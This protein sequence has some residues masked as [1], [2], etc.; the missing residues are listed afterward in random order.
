MNKFSIKD[1]ET[2]TG[3]KSHTIR[4][5]EQRYNFLDTK[6]TDTNIRFYSDDDLRLLLNVATLNDHGYKISEI[7]KMST[8]EMSIK[9][10]EIA[11]NESSYSIYIKSLTS[12][13]L[14]FNE[15]LFKKELSNCIKKIGLEQAVLQ[16]IYPFLQNIGVLWQT[17]MM[18]PAQEHFASS[19]IKQRL[20][21][22]I[23]SL[24][25]Q[26]LESPKKFLLFLPDGEFHEIAL[27]FAYYIIKC[28]GH[29][30]LYLGQ[31]LTINYVKDV[32][33]SYEPDYIFSVLTNSMQE[34]EAEKMLN[35][36][37]SNFQNNQ[38]ILAGGRIQE[39]HSIKPK[40]IV[41]LSEVP[42]LLSFLNELNFEIA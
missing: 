27:L 21:V 40:N 11:H 17:G 33:T 20:I 36:F 29:E 37:E 6:R 38:V 3:I 8:E 4:I 7:A 18:N 42:N 26:E 1:I 19:L 32:F 39:M 28:H 34:E 35:L 10:Q 31:S 16:V 12:H 23:D 14:N 22:A 9:V 13:A 5:W 2:I 30:V 41:F 25:V 24:K 15:K